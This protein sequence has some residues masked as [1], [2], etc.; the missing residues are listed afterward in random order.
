MEDKNAEILAD[1][2]MLLGFEGSE[3]DDILL[4]LIGSVINDALAYCR[5]AFLPRQLY[6][7]IARI[8]VKL[9]QTEGYGGENYAA[10]KLIA[11]GDRR[12]EFDLSA[13]G[14]LGG[15]RDELKPYVNRAGRLPSE[16]RGEDEP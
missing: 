1:V 5:L 11:E 9:W 14:A 6:G 3:H 12:V 4:F 8:T 13:Q 16:V 15:W 10:V 2:K 7:I